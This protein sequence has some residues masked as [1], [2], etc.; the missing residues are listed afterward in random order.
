MF[1]GA[2]LDA[3]LSRKELEADLAGLSLDHSLVVRRVRRGALAARH[4][5]VR[6]PG[7]TRGKAAGH[8]HGAHGHGRSYAAITHLIS[9][10]RLDPEVRERALAIFEAL[11]RAEARVHGITLEKVHF[12][13]VGAVD[14][15]VD[16][17]GAAIALA[18]LDVARVT[19][20]PIALG[21]G[22]VETAHGRL[23][24]PAPATLELLRG[25]PTVPAHVQWET[26]TPTGAAI[27][28][29]VVDEFRALPAMT[30]ESIGHG[31]GN[32]RPGPMPNVLRA[33]LGRSGGASSDR[34]VTL[35]TNLPSTSTTSWSGSSKRAPS[36][37]PSSTCR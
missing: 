20:G 37:S 28:R 18:R 21:E 29:S 7:A 16:V 24:L 4:L 9:R 32:D 26:V 30:I 6:V 35:E 34:V 33:I 10:A 11:G 2:L 25:I 36:T 12:H 23:P 31:A 5:D 27:L 14:A 8:A 17:T 1:L 19:A 15:I 3:G 13:E 22:Q